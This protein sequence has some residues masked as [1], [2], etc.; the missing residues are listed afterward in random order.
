MHCLNA[1]SVSATRVLAAGRPVLAGVVWLAIWCELRRATCFWHG[2]EEGGGGGGGGLSRKHY[3]GSSL[4]TSLRVG[5]AAVGTPRGRNGT[6]RGRNGTPRGRNRDPTGAQRGTRGGGGGKVH[7]PVYALNWLKTI[8]NTIEIQQQQQEQR[9]RF[10]DSEIQRFSAL[11][12]RRSGHSEIQRFRDSE[13]R[14]FGD[15]G[16]QRF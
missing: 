13:F 4:P 2:L 12:I 5:A 10:G 14:R 8:V 15:S 9:L 1:C 16:V 3:Y 7:E 11:E 6:P